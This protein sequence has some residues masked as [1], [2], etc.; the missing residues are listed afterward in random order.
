VLVIG[1]PGHAGQVSPAASSQSVKAKSNFGALSVANSFQ[2]LDLK[3]SVGQ[4]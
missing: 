4:L 2:V 3:P 1:C